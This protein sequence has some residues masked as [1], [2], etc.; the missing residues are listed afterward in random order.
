MTIA[1]IQNCSNYLLR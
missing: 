1:A